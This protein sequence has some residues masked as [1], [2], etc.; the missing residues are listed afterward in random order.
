MASLNPPIGETLVSRTSNFQ[1]LCSA[2]A[3]VHPEKVLG[4]KR[5][6][7]A[8]RPGPDFE[9]DVLLVERVLG[10]EEKLDLALE[11]GFPGR[12][13]LEL[14]FGHGFQLGVGVGVGQD[15]PRIVDVLLDALVFLE[16]PD[17]R[18]ELGPLFGDL[19]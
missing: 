13:P 17:E 4:E 15:L 16:L 1:P 10:E 12:K 7:V 6:L 18:F 11:I 5:G 8:A 19:S 2:I 9:K 3:G 14:G